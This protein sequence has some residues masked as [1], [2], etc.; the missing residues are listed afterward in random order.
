MSLLML[1]AAP[2]PYIRP[3]PVLR[4]LMRALAKLFCGYEDWDTGRRIIFVLGVV[5]FSIVLNFA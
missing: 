3:L 1:G 2:L 5:G 4:K